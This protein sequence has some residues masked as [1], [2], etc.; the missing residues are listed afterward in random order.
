M[1]FSLPDDQCFDLLVGALGLGFVLALASAI[2]IFF[3][4]RLKDC[5]NR[6]GLQRLLPAGPGSGGC[7]GGGDSGLLWQWL[8][9][10]R[11]MMLGPA[12]LSK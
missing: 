3:V 2:P 6:G 12:A 7:H 11:K 10:G 9:G 1:H 4:C 8:G 5:A